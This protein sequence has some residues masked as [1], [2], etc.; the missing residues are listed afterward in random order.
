MAKKYYSVAQ[1]QVAAE[2]ALRNLRAASVRLAGLRVPPRV[3]KVPLVRRRLPITMLPAATE[4][5]IIRHAAQNLGGAIRE[6]QPVQSH[7]L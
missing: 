6:T 7:R 2:T 3:R 5:V 1:S 4:S